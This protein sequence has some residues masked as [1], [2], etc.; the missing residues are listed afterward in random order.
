M[1]RKAVFSG[2]TNSFYP[3]DPDILRREVEGL[4]GTPGPGEP[5]L[6]AIVPHAGYR[7]SGATAGAVYARLAVPPLVILL[8]PNHT[9]SGPPFSLYPSGAWETPLGKV[10]VAPEARDLLAF[11]D[12]LES[13]F[14]AHLGEHSLEVQL[15]FLQ[16][17]AGNGFRV[18]PIALGSH[19]PG[20]LLA[21]GAEIAAFVEKK[22]LSALVLA[23]SDMSHF[24]DDE[25]SRRKDAFALEAV[26][27]LDPGEL[28]R[29]VAR[30]RISMCGVAPAAVMLEAAVRL[31]AATAEILAYT[32]SG[33]ATGDYA[34]V[35]GYAGVVVS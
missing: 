25:T 5:A 33:E 22:G 4:L 23:S 27:S 21:L 17:R 1:L 28:L 8:G 14:L 35:V 6:G 26:E 12:L 31:G 3:E 2:E 16:V 32:T 10:E 15:P 29:R 7:Y 34:R 18:I 9:G 20:A 24:E 11:S 13:D 19:D 30:R